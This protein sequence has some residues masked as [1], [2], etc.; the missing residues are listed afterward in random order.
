MTQ[1]LQQKPEK[2][3]HLYVE[4]G[5]LYIEEKKIMLLF[6]LILFKKMSKVILIFG[7]ASI[8]GRIYIYATYVLRLTPNG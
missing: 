2:L 3:M 8:T 4:R 7:T 5:K 1:L 6:P